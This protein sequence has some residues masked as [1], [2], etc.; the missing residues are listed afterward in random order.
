VR[1]EHIL[2]YLLDMA[3]LAVFCIGLFAV[4]LFNIR[5]RWIA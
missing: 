2:P 3:V 4:S 5:R 1:G